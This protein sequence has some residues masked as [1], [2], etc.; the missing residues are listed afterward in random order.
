M[1]MTDREEPM[2]ERL[3]RKCKQEPFVPMGILMTCGA[4]YFAA[5][6]IKTGDSKLANRM[7]YWRVG[8]QGF[9]VISLVGGGYWMRLKEQNK[10]DREA[11][12]K[13]KAKEREKLWIQELERLDE[14]AKVRQERA[15]SI[16]EAF[17]ERR[18]KANAEEA[19]K[20][21]AREAKK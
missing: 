20:K 16:Q 7:F 15:K 5:K 17:L 10:I 21:E 3:A 1:L 13:V 6:A 2:F 19:A 11:Q 12:L 9:T 8:L 14:E 4:L 18:E